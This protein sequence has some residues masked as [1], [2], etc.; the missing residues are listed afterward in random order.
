MDVKRAGRKD[1]GGGKGV[2][3]GFLKSPPCLF[4]ALKCPLPWLGIVRAEEGH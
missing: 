1:G 2:T 3:V 4:G